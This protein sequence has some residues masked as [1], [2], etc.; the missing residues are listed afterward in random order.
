[1]QSRDQLSLCDETCDEGDR[2]LALDIIDEFIKDAEQ[3]TSQ[4][5][6]V[7]FNSEKANLFEFRACG[8]ICYYLNVWGFEVCILLMN[9]YDFVYVTLSWT[10]EAKQFLAAAMNNRYH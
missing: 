8:K 9:K 1:M 4:V 5:L 6:T 2:N 7:D 3:F 10:V